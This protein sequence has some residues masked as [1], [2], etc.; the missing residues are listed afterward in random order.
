M[1]WSAACQSLARASDRRWLGKQALGAAAQS[2]R[3]RLPNKLWPPVLPRPTALKVWP[4]PT[5]Q[6]LVHM[7]KGLLTLNPYHSDHT[8]L[9]GE[10]QVFFFSTARNCTP[11]RQPARQAAAGASCWALLPRR[12]GMCGKQHVYALRCF[13]FSLLLSSPCFHCLHCSCA[14]ITDHCCSSFSLC[15]HC[16]CGY[17]GGAAGGWA[18][19]EGHAGGEE[20]QGWFMLGAPTC[21][22]C[23]AARLRAQLCTTAPP[24]SLTNLP[25]PPCLR[26]MQGKQHYL[27]YCLTPAMKPRMLMT[28]APACLH[29]VGTWLRPLTLMWHVACCFWLPIAHV[30]HR[31]HVPLH[32]LPP[33]CIHA[34]T[35][36][37]CTHAPLH[38]VWRPGGDA[39]HTSGET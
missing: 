26:A 36:T 4:S 38:S 28:G 34:N 8:L 37:Q 24:H 13:L 15:R 1:H 30:V 23:C 12:T 39:S 29:L 18:G 19:Y 11:H 16:A 14:R 7:G 21:H 27:L 31:C 20:R 35:A 6:G 2:A 25:D 22:A 5:L 10:A 9:N 3:G 17:P 32:A 33:C